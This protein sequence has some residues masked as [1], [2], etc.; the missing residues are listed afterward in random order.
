MCLPNR[1]IPREYPQS[2]SMLPSRI[3][4]SRLYPSE[5]SH[6][7]YRSEHQHRG[8]SS[9]YLSETSPEYQH[10][11][12]YTEYSY[13]E[14]SNILHRGI[15]NIEIEA[16]LQSS[17]NETRDWIRHHSD[18]DR[19]RQLITFLKR[20]SGSG[21]K[22]SLTQIPI[23]TNL[24]FL[25]SVLLAITG[26]NNR[27]RHRVLAKFFREENSK[28]PLSG[29]TLIY[30]YHYLLLIYYKYLNYLRCYISSII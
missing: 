18:D 14:I 22:K 3:T 13:R 16:I 4:T 24:T 15:S 12:Y 21:I 20:N 5:H 25:W 10:R 8:Y 29:Y 7:G 11:D 17:R 19:R 23:F 26:K 9:E 28:W 1:V 6:R 30:F 27:N 2:T